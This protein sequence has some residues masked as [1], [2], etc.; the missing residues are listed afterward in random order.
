MASAAE[1]GQVL[2]AIIT[3]KDLKKTHRWWW[4]RLAPAPADSICVAGSNYT[5]FGPPG[6]I[7]LS[8]AERKRNA[9]RRSIQK[10]RLKSH[11]PT[12]ANT[13]LPRQHLL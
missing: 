9:S 6:I 1:R 2:R 8:Q 11:P 5:A 7:S 13:Q 4:R 10:M 12:P 3:K